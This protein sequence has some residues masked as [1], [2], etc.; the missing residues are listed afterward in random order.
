M[1][2]RSSGSVRVFYPLFNREGLLALLKQR[3]TALQ[4]NLP[5]KRVVLFGSYAKGTQTIGSDIDLLVVYTGE[6]R[7]DAYALVKRTLDIRRLEPHVYAEEEY[8]QVR[9]TVEGMTRDGISV[10][11]VEAGE[12]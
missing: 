3:I 11:N 7:D 12:V 6:P 5:L 8:E 2:S 1:P 4:G 10:L 9:T